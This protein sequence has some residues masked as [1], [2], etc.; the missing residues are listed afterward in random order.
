MVPEKRLEQ[1]DS[2]RGIAALS[3]FF[4]HI[5]LV[6]PQ[7]Q[8][9]QLLFEYSPLRL[10]VAGSEA[11]ILFFVLSGFVLSLPFY[12]DSKSHY[13]SFLTRRVLRIYMPYIFSMI[14]TVLCAQAFYRGKN[15][16]LSNWYNTLWGEGLTVSS[17]AHH[18]FLIKTFLSNLNPVIWS[19]LH[20]M[21]ISLIFPIL[22]FF[23]VKMNWKKNVFMGISF[24][25]LSLLLYQ[26]FRIGNNGVELINTL[27]YMSLFVIGA[28]LGKY[29][30]QITISF[31]KMSKVMKTCFFV[32]E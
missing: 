12:R 6:F 31:K 5:L 16:D 7:N 15:D 3:V 4:G 2:L 32:L 30:S 8:L 19:L 27:H 22:M 24:S 9:S 14:M 26:L 18:T 21:R 23:I 29:F 25:L 1:L 28:V 20:E 13:L 17:I 10:L 11:V